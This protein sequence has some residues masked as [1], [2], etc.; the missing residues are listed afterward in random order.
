MFEKQ[1]TTRPSALAQERLIV[2]PEIV[3]P[4][5]AR[6]V[7]E[8]PVN[9]AGHRLGAESSRSSRPARRR[10]SWR[11][12]D[13]GGHDLGARRR[14]GDARLPGDPGAGRRAR[15]PAHPGDLRHL[16]AHQGAGAA[17]RRDG[18]RGPRPRPLLA[19]R[20]GRRGGVGGDAGGGGGRAADGPRAGHRRLR[21]RAS[22]PARTARG[23][24]SHRADRQ[25]PGR[26]DRLPRRRRGRSRRGRPLL[27]LGGSRTRRPGRPGEMPDAARVRRSRPVRPPRGERPDHRAIAGQAGHRDPTCSPTG[28][29][30]STTRIRPFTTPNRRP[31]P[32]RT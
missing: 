8:D 25:L 2:I 26:G 22:P 9:P 6:P 20:H 7:A 21:C 23:E 29:T 30:P 32:G 12:D 10:V 28:A 1:H 13:H 4:R 14:R 19:D 27:P 17:L 18:L 24:R 3:S 11:H 31:R 15:A 16:R 5:L